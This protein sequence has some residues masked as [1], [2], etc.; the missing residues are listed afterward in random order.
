M[1]QNTQHLLTQ[2]VTTTILP[3][4]HRAYDHWVDDLE[5]RRIERERDVHRATGRRDVAGKTF[6]ILNVARRQCGVVLAFKFS[7]QI[8]WQFAECVHEHTEATTMRHADHGLLHACRTRLL[9]HVIK[10]RNDGVAALAR[11]PFL[12]HVFGVQIALKPLG[13]GQPL[14]NVPLLLNAETRFQLRGLNT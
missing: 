8:S 7:K 11:E 13:S 10:H 6:V 5:M 2:L 3:C 1:Q 14:K 9:Q 12:P 4:A